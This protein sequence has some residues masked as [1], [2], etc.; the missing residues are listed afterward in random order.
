MR[1]YRI[2]IYFSNTSSDVVISANSPAE[3]RRIAVAQY[4]GCRISDSVVEVR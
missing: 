4:T 1:Q 2:R 3:A